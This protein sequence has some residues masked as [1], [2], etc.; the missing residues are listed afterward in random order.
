MQRYF[1]LQQAE[2]LRKRLDPLLREAIGLKAENEEAESNL[3]AVL[4]RVMTLG[5]V[6]IDREA[7]LAQ[8]AR[9]EAS[10]LRLKDAIEQIQKSGCLVKDLDK[11]L[12]DFP[13]LFRGQEVYLCWR[14]GEAGISFWHHVEDGFKGRKLIDQEFL[15]NH[16]GDLSN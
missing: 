6:E 3:R 4:N 13:T 12:L 7:F 15:D 11:G 8:R 14:L 9:R 10:G 16:Q 5:G 2:A 1:T